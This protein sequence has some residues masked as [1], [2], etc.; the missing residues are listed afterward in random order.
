M[1]A[2]AIRPPPASRQQRIFTWTRWTF[3]TTNV[4]V[5]KC[6]RST[7]RTTTFFSLSRRNDDAGRLRN[8]SQ[9]DDR[10]VRP[11]SSSHRQRRGAMRSELFVFR[12][13]GEFE[14]IEK[15]HVHVSRP[16]RNANHRRSFSQIRLGEFSHRLHSRHVRSGRAVFGHFRRRFVAS[17]QE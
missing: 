5:E 8:I 12:H 17:R 9:R 10:S 15:H 3:S 6:L 11:E 2:K 4:Q 1:T 14:Q 13:H 16:S 7:I